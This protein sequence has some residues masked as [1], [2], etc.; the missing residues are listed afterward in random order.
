MLYV[1][2]ILGWYFLFRRFPTLV[3]SF[4]VQLELGM[5][6]YKYK[7]SRFSVMYYASILPRILISFGQLQKIDLLHCQQLISFSPTA[8]S[9]HPNGVDFLSKGTESKHKY[10]LCI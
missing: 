2:S 7:V 8:G 6:R 4:L 10:E 1:P 5:P 9:N 3:I